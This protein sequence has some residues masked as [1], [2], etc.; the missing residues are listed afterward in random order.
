MARPAT[1][2]KDD[3]RTP[4]EEVQIIRKGTKNTTIRRRIKAGHMW[5]WSSTAEKVPTER[6]LD[7][8]AAQWRNY[9]NNPK[10]ATWHSPQGTPQA[11]L[12]I[13]RSYQHITKAQVYYGRDEHGTSRWGEVDDIDSSNVV[14]DGGAGWGFHPPAWE[15]TPPADDDGIDD[16]GEVDE[17]TTAAGVS[18]PG[19]KV[20]YLRVS[21]KDQN[22]SRQRETLAATGITKEFVD[23]ISARS[24]ADR[25]GLEDCMDY[26]RDGDELHVASI[27]RLARSL[28]DLKQIIAELTDKGVTV[29]FHKEGLRFA[30]GNDD[31]TANLMLGILGSFA[32]FERSIIRERQAEG[33]ALAKKAGKYTGRPKALREKEVREVRQRAAEGESKTA[34]A[35]D[36][37]ISRATLYRYL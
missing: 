10:M 9:E 13:Q 21:T 24:R 8:G 6:V 34:I 25:P 36:L 15:T 2:L 35:K 12:E 17:T 19:H 29:V 28:V 4:Q 7:D 31:P 3:L 5:T 30:A 18:A 14:L 1:L 20:A 32:E 26:L 23:E 37:G 11:L 27:D 16:Q 33:I 22:L